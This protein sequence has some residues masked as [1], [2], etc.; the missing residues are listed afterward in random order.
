MTPDK[1]RDRLP[2]QLLLAQQADDLL[3]VKPG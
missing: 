2:A 3:L 1:A